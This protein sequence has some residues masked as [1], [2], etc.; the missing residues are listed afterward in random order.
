[1][2]QAGGGGAPGVGGPGTSG[3]LPGGPTNPLLCGVCHD[4]YSDPCLL[5]CYHTFCAR[6]L[7][8]PHL[9]GKV[10]CPVCGQITQLK[11]GAHQPPCDQLMR[12]L[13]EFANCENPPCANCDKRDKTT[14]YFCTTCGQAL[15]PHCREHTHRAKMFSSH[16]VVHMSKC[17]K[18]TQRRCPSH[19]EQYIMF[20]QSSKAMLCA[21]CFRDTPADARLHCVDIDTAW[22]QASK[23]MERAANS[24]CELQASVR[25]GLM[26]LKSQLD[27]LRH[28]LETEKRALNAYCQGMQDAVNKTHA[29]VLS[30]LHR[31]FDTK[32]RLVRTQLLS[33]GSALPVLQ[34]HLGL[35]TAF[36]SAATKYQFLELAHPML[37]R[38]GRVAQLGHLP[39][40][41]LLTAQLKTNYKGDFVRV[42]QPYVGNQANSTPTTKDTL[43]YDQMQSQQQQESQFIT[44]AMTTRL[45]AKSGSSGSGLFETGRFSSHC[46]TFDNQL[47]EL[48]NQLKMVRERL[49]ELHRDVA[50]LRKANTP[51]LGTRYEN[52][53]RDCRLLEQQLEH[54]QMELER[55]RS[56]FDAL[57]EEQLCRIHLEKEVFHSQMNDILELKGEVKQ[58]QS[59]AQQLEPFV[60]SFAA[61]VTAGE[62]SQAAADVTSE[63]HL[64]AL[65]DHLQR[66]QMQDPAQMRHQRPTVD[67]NALYKDSKEVPTRCRTPSS[68]GGGVEAILDSSGNIVVYPKPVESKQGVL[69]Q[70]IEKAR[71]K[72]DRKK[73]PGREDGRDRSQTRRSSRK[74]P[75]NAKP[76]TP[77]GHSSSTSKVRSLY[78]QLKGGG[79]GGGGGESVEALDQQADHRQQQQLQQ[80]GH[81]GEE[82]EYQRISEASSMAEVKKRVQA[83]VHAIPGDERVIMQHHK[84]SSSS[85]SKGVKVYPASD[86]ED[87]FYEKNPT[88]SCRER[89][90]RRASCDSLSTTGS[91]SRRSSITG[92][93]G[94]LDMPG[95]TAQDAKRTLFFLVKDPSSLQSLVQKQRSWETF[96]RPKSKRTTI[97]I[98]PPPPPPPPSSKAPGGGSSVTSNVLNQ[99][100]KADSFEGHEEAVRTLVAAVQETRSQIRQQQMQHRY[101]RKSKTN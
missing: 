31:E 96:P 16:E 94:A 99:L 30:E 90:R 84:S 27:E 26:D 93:G 4:Y 55:L 40:P 41:P 92:P 22:Q 10:S 29:S 14:M 63:P 65:L 12:Q 80:S 67:N 42:L 48:S 23:K 32:E 88:E 20:S 9:D 3:G 8:G 38:L 98:E 21:T 62:L 76:K 5:T 82:C 77:P 60:K 57:W 70:L 6:C 43:L 72:E 18:E 89:R 7:R 56:V 74:S 24:I 49:G 33:L 11:E 45:Q 34:M 17:S 37:D 61:G 53:A 101:H 91:G 87:V 97:S 73:S 36:T 47:Q 44:R 13:V 79:G 35:C 66:L 50:L 58:L 78:R 52:V 39:R 2:S 28:S 71:T 85:S 25:D 15:C 83:Q 81:Q 46:R 19:G 100:K 1:M 51:P 95:L 69:R 64:Q 68:A 86:S 59:V 54:Q 75:E